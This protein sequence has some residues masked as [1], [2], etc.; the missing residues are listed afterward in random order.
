M[1][2]NQTNDKETYPK[3]EHKARIERYKFNDKLFRG[4]HYDAFG[5]TPSDPLEPK[6]LSRLRYTVANFPAMISKVVA[7]MLFSEPPKFKVNDEAQQ[8]FIDGLV[9]Q[10]NLDAQNYESSLGNSRH[11]DALYKVRTGKLSPSDTEDTVIIEDITPSIYF[12]ELNGENAREKPSKSELAWPLK[13]GEKDYLR[14]EIH[15]VGKIINELWLLESGE[16]KTKVSLDLLGEDGL[17]EVVLTDVDRP[18]LVHVPNWRDASTF[19][20]YDDYSDLITIFYEINNR[21][22]RTSRTL[23]KHSSPILAMPEGMLDEKG[24]INQQKVDVFEF[25]N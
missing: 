19:F 1:A 13:I 10:N 25:P 7:D 21:I 15:E 24:N 8:K 22:A 2:E 16:V 12:P 23:N 3:Q 18:L 6:G 20:G 17:E 5:I 4:N 11:G 14:K 9:A